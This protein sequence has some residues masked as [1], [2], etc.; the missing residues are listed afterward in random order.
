VSNR[1]G[2]R[3]VPPTIAPSTGPDRNIGFLGAL[4]NANPQR[5][6]GGARSIPARFF[7]RRRECACDFVM[8]KLARFCAAVFASAPRTKMSCIHPQ[9]NRVLHLCQ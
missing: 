5:T 8:Q 9:L 2:L 3:I 7:V 4:N 6:F 1:T